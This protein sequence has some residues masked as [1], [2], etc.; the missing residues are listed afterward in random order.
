MKKVVP[1]ILQVLGVL[2]I[3]EIISAIVVL[4]VIYSE[5][6]IAVLNYH[7]VLAKEEIE[8]LK[9]EKTW[10]IS[11]D[12]FEEQMKYLHDH[13][14]K[15]L[16]M[17]EFCEWKEGKINL[18]FKSVLITFDDGLLSNYHYAFPILKKYNLNA[19]LFLIGNMSEKIGDDE[20]IWLGNYNSYISKNQI[21]EI[22]KDY[23]NIEIYSHTYG[24]HRKIKGREAVYCYT[25]EQMQED[26]EK[27]ENY[28]G[29]TEIVA[30]P[31]GVTDPMYVDVLKE[32]GYKYGFLL[33]DNKKATRKDD[34]FY[35]NRVNLSRD[36]DIL[37][38]GLRLLL[39]F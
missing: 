38:F 11:V 9:A 22:K 36:K 1:K 5:P 14:Y 7:N 4:I 31:F 10:S 15:T 21:E 6:K 24:M 25:R 30:Y 39:P 32:N 16:T 23:P 13:N 19:T 18:P 35:I 27:Y 3:L 12:N 17:Q 37:H 20:N 2:F 29:K 8:G 28:M 33:G 26:I 34:N